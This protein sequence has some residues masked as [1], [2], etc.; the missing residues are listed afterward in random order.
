MGNCKFLIFRLLA[1][2][3]ESEPPESPAESPV[4]ESA[5]DSVAAAEPNQDSMASASGEN[6]DPEVAKSMKCDV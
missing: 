2:N 5:P 6:K 3:D 1:H 4:G